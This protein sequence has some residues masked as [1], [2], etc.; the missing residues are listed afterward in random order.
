M[1]KVFRYGSNTDEARLNS[2]ERLGGA[3]TNGRRAETIEDFDLAFN[4]WSVKNNCAAADL[5]Q[6]RAGRH[7]ESCWTFPTTGSTDLASEARPWPRS[8][9]RA[10]RKSQL[11]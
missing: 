7:G 10:T 8:K 9:D 6:L 2:V 11:R 3:A 4:V 1:G 5:V